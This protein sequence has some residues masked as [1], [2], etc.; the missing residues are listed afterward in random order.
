MFILYNANSKSSNIDNQ[1]TA[2]ASPPLTKKKIHVRMRL[3]FVTLLIFLIV[4]LLNIM[5]MI[6]FLQKSC[7]TLLFFLYLFLLILFTFFFRRQWKRIK[8]VQH[9]G[10]IWGNYGFD[11]AHSKPAGY[12]STSK[13][14]KNWWLLQLYLLTVTYKPEYGSYSQTCSNWLKLN[15]NSKQRIILPV[16][17]NISLCHSTL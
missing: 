10:S 12:H 3:H 1:T 8:K 17:I 6:H 16:Y 9:D 7:V 13:V 4:F 14:T 5:S 2:T 15:T 11:K